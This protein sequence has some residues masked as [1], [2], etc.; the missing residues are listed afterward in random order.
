MIINL[1]RYK[2]S[3]I[4]K[5]LLG[6]LKKMFLSLNQPL[7]L[8]LFSTM[9]KT[10][11]YQGYPKYL[12]DPLSGVDLCTTCR[13]CESICPSGSIEITKSNDGFNG[14][15]N[16]APKEFKLDLLSCVKCGFCISDCPE[17]AL[18]GNGEFEQSDFEQK[19]I[20]LKRKVSDTG[21]ST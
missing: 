3:S 7:V 18:S 14:P 5:G 13:I 4:N 17:G 6:I 16:K 9:R 8:D 21:I 10:R 15:I 20:D 19:V 2:E 12:V 11:A 1:K